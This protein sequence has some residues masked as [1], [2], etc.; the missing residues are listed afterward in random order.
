MHVIQ[1]IINSQKVNMGGIILEQPLPQGGVE[2]VDPYLLIHHWEETLPGNQHQRDVGVGPHPHRGFSPITFIYSGA[3]HHKDSLGHDS[4]VEAGGTQWMFSGKGITHSE[5]PPAALAEK[6]GHFEFIQIWLNAPAKYKMD[7]PKYMPLSAADTPS[8]KSSDGLVQ[9]GVVSGSFNEIEGAIKH[10]SDVDIFRLTFTEGGELNVPIKADY[11]TCFYVLD[12][13]VVLDDQKITNK[14]LVILHRDL[15]EIKLKA[16]AHTR[17][18]FLSGLPINEKIAQYGP[19]VMNTQ[20]E[21]MQA[22]RDAQM[23]KMG[24]LIE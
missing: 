17:I 22:M 16:N 4:I 20:T 18:L 24:I 7:T 1:K 19:F 9:I 15:G 3:V 6:G 5:R 13:E 10:K 8:F 23:G 14:Q 2:H 21:V 11:Q 12:G